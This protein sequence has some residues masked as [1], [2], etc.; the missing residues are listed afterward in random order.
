MSSSIEVRF[1]LEKSPAA[2]L[3]D[4]FAT[5]P[6]AFLA[7]RSASH[8]TDRASPKSWAQDATC[9]QPQGL[10]VTKQTSKP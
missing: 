9:N 1:L 7:Y 6:A 3:T 5:I 2:S 8:T 10:L 4:V